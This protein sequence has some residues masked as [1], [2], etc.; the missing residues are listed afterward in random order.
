MMFEVSFIGFHYVWI[1]DQD[2]Q[3]KPAWLV[4]RRFA[5]FRTTTTSFADSRSCGHIR[6]VLQLAGQIERPA[7][8]LPGFP[9]VESS[10]S[11]DTRDFILDGQV[12]T[13]Q[14]QASFP[15]DGVDADLVVSGGS[16]SPLAA[17][18]RL[19]EETLTSCWTANRPQF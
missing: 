17:W 1:A 14:T 12:Y 8:S 2:R 9:T 18:A 4:S 10:Q 13:L 11:E 3:R 16:L 6:S 7:V 19:V 5:D 15:T